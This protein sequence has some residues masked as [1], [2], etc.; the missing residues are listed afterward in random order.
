M[1]LLISKKSKRIKT[2]YLLSLKQ[3]EIDV[4]GRISFFF[5]IFCFFGYILNGN[6]N[7]FL[8]NFIINRNCFYNIKI[9][10]LPNKMSN[11]NYEY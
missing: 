9:S 4:E 11:F 7:Y 1:R 8:I 2:M 10:I 5:N 3:M 6:I